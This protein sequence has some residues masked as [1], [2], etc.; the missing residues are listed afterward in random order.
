MTIRSR[1][2]TS[3]FTKQMLGKVLSDVKIA[4]HSDKDTNKET[5]VFAAAPFN[6]ASLNDP[7]GKLLYDQIM[8]YCNVL[9]INP[10][11]SI[12]LTNASA[13]AVG[14]GIKGMGEVIVYQQIAELSVP[15]AVRVIELIESTEFGSDKQRDACLDVFRQVLRYLSHATRFLLTEV[16]EGRSVDKKINAFSEEEKAAYLEKYVALLAKVNCIV[17]ELNVQDEPFTMTTDADWHQWLASQ[18]IFLDANGQVDEFLIREDRLIEEFDKTKSV[19][20]QLLEALK[21]TEFLFFGSMRPFHNSMF[22]WFCK[23]GRVYPG[24]Q[25]DV[26]VY[27]YLKKFHPEIVET[28][29]AHYLDCETDDN[30]TVKAINRDLPNGQVKFVLQLPESL[31]PSKDVEVTIDKKQTTFSPELKAVVLSRIMQSQYSDFEQRDVDYSEL[32]MSA[33]A[34]NSE[35]LYDS[36]SRNILPILK[37]AN[38]VY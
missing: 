17:P 36:D 13:E 15:F 14:G 26:S 11:P 2:V 16:R 31:D 24:C 27:M 20:P 38:V 5:I 25:F 9:S 28:L 10:M 32:V 4:Q 19:P 34:R 22:R 3:Q 18:N 7:E 8:T 37:N 23:F 12:G 35:V 29:V 1:L 6:V 30:N 33:A 21:N